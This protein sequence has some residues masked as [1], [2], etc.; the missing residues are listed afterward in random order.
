MAGR[1]A[2]VLVDHGSRRPE[3]NAVLDGIAARLR[4]R[5]PGRLVRVAH[6]ELAAPGLA[7]AVAAC[8][9]EGAGEIVVLPYFL[10]PGEHASRDVPALAAAAAARHPD[11]SI[12]VAEPLGVHEGL[13]DAV[14]ARV[15]GA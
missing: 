15:E 14:L 8:V 7:E 5:L 4:A 11:V 9:A 2:I 3:A 6:L 1:R 13:V 12:R 10:A